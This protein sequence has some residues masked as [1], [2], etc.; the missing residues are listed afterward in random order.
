L[1]GVAA[2]LRL[3]GDLAG[4]EALLR[5]S[6]EL[7]RRTRGEYH[8][9]TGTSMHD[10][11]IVAASKGDYAAA[12]SLLRQALVINRRA[13]GD[14]HPV[15]AMTLNALSRVLVGQQRYD[16]AAADLESALEIARPALGDQHQLVAIY[17][18]NLAAVQLTR[19]NPEAA[20][21]LI[22][23]A[24]PVRMLA[25][26]LVPN[27]RRTFPEDDWS[28]GAA[29][30]LFGAALLELG[31]L[32]EAETALL[33]AL[34]DLRA[35]PSPSHRDLTDTIGRLVELYRAMG[36]PDRARSYREELTR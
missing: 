16:E 25:P 15:V 30:S 33:E 21:L 19:K 2:V 35:M 26:G 1:N 22:R 20:E 23:Q 12:E 28:I 3:N 9:N 13:L 4:A 11:G 10:L 14:S 8:A 5:Q 27:R 32:P 29:K 17:S 34:D 7:N 6:L 18:I 31:R 24:L 36:T